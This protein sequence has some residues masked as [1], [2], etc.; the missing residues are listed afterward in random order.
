MGDK[1]KAFQ[2]NSTLKMKSFFSKKEKDKEF[3]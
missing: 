3:A 1:V 2:E